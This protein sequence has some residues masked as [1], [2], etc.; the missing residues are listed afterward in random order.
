MGVLWKDGEKR[1]PR[2]DNSVYYGR[3]LS[4]E[5]RRISEPIT[6]LKVT[7]GLPHYLDVL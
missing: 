7:D 5:R 3:R 1:D 2:V 4:R 6:H